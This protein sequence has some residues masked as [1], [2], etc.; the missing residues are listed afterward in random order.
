MWG[1]LKATPP[2]TST[3]GSLSRC[4]GS[5]RDEG[6]R[7]DEREKLGSIF[8]T[9]RT[10]AKHIFSF[11]YMEECAHNLLI[12]HRLRN[13]V[14]KG[15]FSRKS[16]LRFKSNEW[17]Q[18][19]SQLTTQL[20]TRTKAEGDATPSSPCR[21]SQVRVCPTESVPGHSGPFSMAQVGRSWGWVDPVVDL[22][23]HLELAWAQ[24]EVAA[25]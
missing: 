24:P 5:R 25:Q 9:L 22:F 13:P 7:E 19:V 12:Y 10:Y 18:N 16:F 14:N 20:N 2:R 8:L 17:A 21:R 3:P 11:L 23:P 1:Y 6:G 4:A 15:D